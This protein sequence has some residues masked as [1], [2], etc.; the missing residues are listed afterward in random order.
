[1]TKEIDEGSA[2]DAN[3]FKTLLPHTFISIWKDNL[4]PRF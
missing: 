2:K 3:N 4:P 1:M